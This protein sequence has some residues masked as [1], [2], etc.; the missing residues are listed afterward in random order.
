[1]RIDEA[2][3]QRNQEASAIKLG[4]GLSSKAPWFGEIAL[5]RVSVFLLE[6]ACNCSG[7]E[8]GSELPPWVV[9]DRTTLSVVRSLTSIRF[10][11]G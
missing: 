11:T 1:M 8:R 10:N 4:F 3:V 9:V 2:A 5:E 6:A 7:R